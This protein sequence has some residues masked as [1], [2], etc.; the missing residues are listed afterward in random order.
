MFILCEDCKQKSESENILKWVFFFLEI[1][2]YSKASSFTL[3][4]AV[5][6]VPHLGAVL[7]ICH[8]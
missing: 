4:S 1:L 7:R 2:I 5:N 8:Y 6:I 3:A